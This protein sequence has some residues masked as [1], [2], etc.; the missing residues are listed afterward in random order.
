MSL[1]GPSIDANEYI[2]S[3][4]I[5]HVKTDAER[6]SLE[7]T[8]PGTL[9]VTDSRF[10]FI[11]G[12]KAIDLDVHAIDEIVFRPSYLPL[13]YI[14][15]ATFAAVA[16]FLAFDGPPVI[17]IGPPA[18]WSV[19]AI[20]GFIFAIILVAAVI[21]EYGARLTIKTSQSTYQFRSDDL[22]D[23]PHA[24]RGARDR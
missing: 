19:L 5:V 13:S 8:R 16:S 12:S 23:V 10:V 2:Q 6:R 21:T 18:A 22:S 24:I 15:V 3:G 14:A 9:M 1:I 7:D 17:D 20:G 4:E 11:D